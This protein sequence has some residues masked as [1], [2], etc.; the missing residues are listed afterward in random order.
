[1]QV[2]V[3]LCGLA[4]ITSHT[5]WIYGAGS[6]SRYSDYATGELGLDFQQEEMIYFFSTAPGPNLVSNESRE[7]VP[8]K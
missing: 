2:R 5:V 3:S 8:R 6:L 4:H 1:M 7:L